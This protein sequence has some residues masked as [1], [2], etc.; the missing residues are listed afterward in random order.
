M[1]NWRSSAME[2]RS[3]RVRVTPSP[4]GVTEYVKTGGVGIL[5]YPSS[6]TPFSGFVVVPG[7]RVATTGGGSPSGARLLS[8]VRHVVVGTLQSYPVL[9]SCAIASAG[10]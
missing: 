6:S 3:L 4:S 1:A 10:Y 2:G 5:G 9:L 7:D 8:P